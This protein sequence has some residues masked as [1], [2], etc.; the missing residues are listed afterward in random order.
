MNWYTGNAT[1]DSLL[2]AGFI[3]ALLVFVSSKMGT[4]QYGG[5]FGA[6][7]GG[8]K[9]SSK[10]GWILMEIPALIAFPIFFFMG[11]NAVQAV[12]LFFLCLWVFH[13]INRAIV[14]PMLM[15]TTTGSSNSFAINVV[16][17]GWV[18][19]VLHSYLNAHYITEL[20]NHYQDSWFQDP[21]FIIGI[22]IYATGFTLNVYSDNISSQSALQKS[23]S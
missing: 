7:A 23:R 10:V 4:A 18:T 14:T 2:I 12:P 17:L 21:R 22:I 5:R 6:G 1:Y 16:I 3:L 11:S 15:R 20:G 9:L 19:L 13:Y 8:F